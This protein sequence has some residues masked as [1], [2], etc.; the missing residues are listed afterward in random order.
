MVHL[1]PVL[2]KAAAKMAGWQGH[3]FNLGGHWEDGSRLAGH[4]CSDGA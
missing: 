4:L 3:L 1:Q 2:D